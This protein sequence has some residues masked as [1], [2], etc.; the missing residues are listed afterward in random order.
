MFTRVLLNRLMKNICPLVLPKSQCGFC[1]GRETIDII[2]TAC[3]IQER[4]IEQYLKQDQVFVDLAKA[5]DTVN[6]AA[7]W[8][9]LGKLGCPPRFVDILRQLH[10]DM[11]THV[12]YNGTLSRP[13]SV[14]NGVQQGDVLSLILFAI[15]FAVA[16]VLAFQTCNTGAYIRYLMTGRL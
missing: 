5:F 2:F 12:C 9:I 1:S 4:C 10:D 14:D 8:M 6:R 7:L 16:L 11:K 15:Y 13:I 3:Q